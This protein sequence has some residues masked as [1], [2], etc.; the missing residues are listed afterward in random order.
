MKTHTTSL[1]HQ[2]L[3]AMINCAVLQTAVNC[4]P[5]EASP[6]WTVYLRKDN[7]EQLRTPWK[8]TQLSTK[9]GTCSLALLTLSCWKFPRSA[10]VH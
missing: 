3:R 2:E 9:R 10:W 1:G 7:Y 8:S 4:A 6:L 5:N